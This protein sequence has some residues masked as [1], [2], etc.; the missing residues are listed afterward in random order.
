MLI[1]LS[2]FARLGNG[3][4]ASLGYRSGATDMRY[5]AL[6]L[7]AGT[8]SGVRA[9]PMPAYPRDG[10][11]E[12]EVR[13]EIPHVDSRKYVATRRI[14]LAGA[15]DGLPFPVL[16]ANNP[17]AGCQAR[18]VERDGAR[19]SYDIVC[20]GRDAARAHAAYTLT[21]DAFAGRIAM[22]LGGKNM[23]MVETQRGRRSGGCDL[24]AA[25][26]G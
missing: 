8:A 17:F 23:T 15:M 26:A 13:T 24:A 18:N 19:L 2:S 7:L 25:P 4:G 20:S 16:G 9:E 12:V 11:Y 1:T 14:C 3:R 21:P 10:S 22:R 6:I 5:M